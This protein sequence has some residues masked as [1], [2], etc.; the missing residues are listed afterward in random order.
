MVEVGPTR[1]TKIRAF[2]PGLHGGVAGYPA[3]FTV[4]TNGETGGLGLHLFDE[5]LGFY[6]F[7]MK[8]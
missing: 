2:G 7:S 6:E 5:V 4:E 8:G 3:C 1:P